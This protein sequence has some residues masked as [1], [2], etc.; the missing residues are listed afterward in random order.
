M[1]EHTISLGEREDK[2]L[3]RIIIVIFGIMCIFTALWW[4]VFLIKFP[5]NEKIFWAG[6][7]FLLLF[8]IYQVY[9]GFGFARRYI[10]IDNTNIIIRQNSLLPPRKIRAGEI[11]QLEIRTYDMVFHINDSSRLRIKLGLKYPDL[12]QRVRDF[13]TDYAKTNNIEIFYKNEPL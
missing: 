8:G 11:T 6:S 13:I 5:D 10:R 3:V 9:A 7:I 4:A 12:G 2:L 1:E